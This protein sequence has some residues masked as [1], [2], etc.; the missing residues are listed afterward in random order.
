MSKNKSVFAYFLVLWE[1]QC[2]I[3]DVKSIRRNGALF[4]TVCI[5][6][7]MVVSSLVGGLCTGLETRPA[8]SQSMLMI[9]QFVKCY[10]SKAATRS[11]RVLTS[12]GRPV[13]AVV[14]LQSC[15]EANQ[16]FQVSELE[17][18]KS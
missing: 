2:G 11:A 7:V 5:Q 6:L 12:M 14:V 15:L 4:V 16:R 13:E 3:F 1:S 10:L 18:L 8:L 9:L 17:V